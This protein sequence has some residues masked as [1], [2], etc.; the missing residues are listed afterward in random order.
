[1]STI[2]ISAFSILL[3]IAAQAPKARTWTDS[4]GK[5]SFTGDLVGYS[6]DTVI[7][8]RTNK[9]KDLVAM[10]IDKLSPT[11]QEYLKSKEGAESVRRSA[12]KQQAWTMRNGLKV[13][14]RVVE[15][16]RR[17]LTIQRKRGKLYVN[18]RPLSNYH[19]LQQ[20]VMARIVA[21]FENEM[22]EDEKDLEKWANSKLKGDS[23]TY[24]VEGVMMELENG[25]VY[26]VPFFFFSEEDLAVLDPGWRRWLAADSARDQANKAQQQK[27]REELM[28]RATAEA[29]QRDRQVNQ[30]IK[31]VELT[32]LA[33]AAGATDL[34]EVQLYPPRGVAEYPRVVVVPGKNSADA[35]QIAMMRFP[36]YTAGSVAQANVRY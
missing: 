2:L 19:D 28:L 9:E 18:D 3:P 16:G 29:Y 26:G 21:H 14:G 24:T 34:W 11:D 5:Y 12:D 4:T 25:D 35:K 30:Q 6:D 23:R 20:R 17:E 33:T 7:V 1:M 27:E 8:Q 10:A 15:Y 31:H 36:G 22:I 13:L 32:L